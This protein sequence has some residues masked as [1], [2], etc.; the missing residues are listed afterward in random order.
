MERA[1]RMLQ[2]GT[3]VGQAAFALGYGSDEAFSRAFRRHTGRSPSTV[4]GR[5][6]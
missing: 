1:L 6:P 5:T 3:S 4:R 2:D